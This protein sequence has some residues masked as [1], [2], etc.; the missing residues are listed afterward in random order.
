MLPTLQLL[1]DNVLKEDDDDV[2]MTS[3]IKSGV[4][5]ELENTYDNEASLK[6]MRLSALLEIGRAHV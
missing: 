3:V 6:L 1:K 2:R 5:L 4:L